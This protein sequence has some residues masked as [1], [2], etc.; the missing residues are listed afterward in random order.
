MHC[1]YQLNYIHENILTIVDYQG[2]ILLLIFLFQ[3]KKSKHIIYLINFKVKIVN[4]YLDLSSS[5]LNQ[6]YSYFFSK[7]K[8]IF[9]HLH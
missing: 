3:V 4:L 8:I 9:Y 6:T 2:N 1:R 5:L 7:I